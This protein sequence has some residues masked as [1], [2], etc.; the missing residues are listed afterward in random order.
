MAIKLEDGQKNKS[1][2]N[3]Q[4]L[5]STQNRSHG[6]V[7]LYGLAL[8]VH[9]GVNI[10][11]APTTVMDSYVQRRSADNPATSTYKKN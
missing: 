3:R 5:F 8:T 6:S 9:A 10:T 7:L 11:A 4:N 2:E 1:C